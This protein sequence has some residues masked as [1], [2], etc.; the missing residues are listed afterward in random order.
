MKKVFFMFYLLAFTLV[1]SATLQ[2]LRTEYKPN[3]NISI[4]VIDL[5][6]NAKNWLA[7]YAKDDN[8]NWENV[9][10][11]QW[12]KE[13]T[14]GDFKF[15]GLPVGDYQA[16]VFYNNTFNEE[17]VVNFLV[18]SEFNTNTSVETRKNIYKSNETIQV[19]TQHM[20]GHPQ[21]WIAIYPKG[22]SNAWEN[23]IDWH[24]LNGTISTIVAFDALSAGEYEI[25]AFFKNYY[26]LEAKH[27]FS[28]VN[29]ISPSVHSQQLQ[30]ETDEALILKFKNI[31]V[32]NKN[33]VGIYPKG[34]S[35]AWENVVKWEW[36]PASK[37]SNLSIKRLPIGQ[38]QARIF[39]RNTFNTEA[40]V[41]FNIVEVNNNFID[42]VRRHCIPG[43]EDKNSILCSNELN[44]A[45]A[46]NYKEEVF[47]GVIYD[48]LR[49]DLGNN[50]T[51]TIEANQKL[52]DHDPDESLVLIRL[53]HTP[54][55][56]Y[57]KIRRG[58]DINIEWSFQYQGQTVLSGYSN[59]RDK[60]I[61]NVHSTNK[62]KNLVFTY[63]NEYSEPFGIITKTYDISDPKTA[64]LIDTQIKPL[65]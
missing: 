7:I 64:T 9:L 43:H 65:H 3:A 41:D 44:I 57:K 16:R 31:Q 4:K 2:S 22:S 49:I 27:S 32:F 62:G 42:E 51:Q 54:I 18:R 19:L 15:K 24:Y 20:S 34:T 58:G 38:Y 61:Y 46:I 45:Y 39:Y 37:N 40:T 50:T 55:Y 12:T 28:V 36:L 25:R 63:D 60:A 59:D 30:Y 26:H 21:D 29:E 10:R 5:E 14:T 1:H 8:N 48:F 13:T 17:A 23:V 6:E 47:Q 52:S 35:N 33:W 11:W 53:D 56:L